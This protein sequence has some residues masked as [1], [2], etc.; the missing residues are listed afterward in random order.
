MR[1]VGIFG[2]FVAMQIVESI[3]R[4]VV[5]VVI[6]IKFTNDEIDEPT[7]KLHIVGRICYI[8]LQAITGFFLGVCQVEGVAPYSDL[9][10]DIVLVCLLNFV[11]CLLIWDPKRS[12]QLI[13]GIPLPTDW[14]KTKNCYLFRL[15]KMGGAMWTGVLIAILNVLLYVLLLVVP[16]ALNVTLVSTKV[17]V[18]LNLVF[19]FVMIGSCVA[20]CTCWGVFERDKSDSYSFM[21][22]ESPAV[23][24]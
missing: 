23:V 19:M 1:D 16:T 9:S 6:R 13:L 15:K 12:Y 5:F 2:A 22:S 7:S 3:Y 17:S 8:F 20:F 24:P 10:V 4:T 14:L 18:I 21:E 11:N